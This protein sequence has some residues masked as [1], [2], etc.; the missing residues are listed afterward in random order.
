MAKRKPKPLT[1]EAKKSV[2]KP[3]SLEDLDKETSRIHSTEPKEPIPDVQAPAKVQAK[4]EVAEKKPI[5]VSVDTPEDI[6]E[7]VKNAMRQLPRK[8]RKL[9]LFYLQAVIEKCERMGHKI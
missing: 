7:M 1:T 8:E 2:S 9:R 6:Y 3:V 5:R 4:V